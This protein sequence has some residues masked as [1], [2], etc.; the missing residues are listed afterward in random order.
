MILSAAGAL[1]LPGLAVLAG[2]SAARASVLGLDRDELVDD[3]VQL[4]AAPA[5][6]VV[7]VVALGNRH[8]REVEAG[9]AAHPGP[10]FLFRLGH[11]IHSSLSFLLK[12][13]NQNNLGDGERGGGFNEG[14]VHRS[15]RSFVIH[16][17]TYTLS[18]V[19]C[20]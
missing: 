3:R 11:R 7:D 12:I 8:P 9:V 5:G 1:A 13:L 2:A 19:E 4:A 10:V 18:M 20:Q 14:R 17:L 15:L 6:V 16:L